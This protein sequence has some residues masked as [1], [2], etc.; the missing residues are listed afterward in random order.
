MLI[1]MQPGTESEKRIKLLLLM[2]G[3]FNENTQ[4]ALIRHFTTGMT[5]DMCCCLHDI[6]IPNF[7]RSINR[8][9]EMNDLVEQVKELDIYHLSDKCEQQE[10][11]KQ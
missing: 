1:P 9:N 7:M 8:L 2:V 3:K 10:T 11:I 6:K 5:I 4:E